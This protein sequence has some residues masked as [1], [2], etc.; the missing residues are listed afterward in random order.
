[1]QSFDSFARA[2][3]IYGLARTSLTGSSYINYDC[4]QDSQAL[5]GV[6]VC[7]IWTHEVFF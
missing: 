5:D 4:Q 7:C 6:Y 2:S 1:M 3:E